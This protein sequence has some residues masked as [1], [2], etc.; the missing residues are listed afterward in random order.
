MCLLHQLLLQL[1]E[2]QAGGQVLSVL[3]RQAS[4]VHVCLRQRC[5]HVQKR[6]L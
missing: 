5:R 3:L 4:V 2:Q 1:F 6:Q